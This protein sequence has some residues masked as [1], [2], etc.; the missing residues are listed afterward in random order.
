[1]PRTSRSSSADGA[2]AAGKPWPGR[3]AAD[4]LTAR[5]HRID[6]SGL[7]GPLA[8][9]Y[10]RSARHAWGLRW[11]GYKGAGVAETR[12]AIVD[13]LIRRSGVAV[14]DDHRARLAEIDDALDALV[15]ALVARAVRLGLTSAPAPGAELDTARREG[16][17]HTP[18]ADALGRLSGG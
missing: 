1:M 15:C 13:A 8:E 16:W 9:V 17:I 2:H 14:D 3:M 10:P 5:G 6:R 18:S 7:V 12:R 11:K 4:T